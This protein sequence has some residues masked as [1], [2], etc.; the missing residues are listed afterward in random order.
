MDYDALVAT[1]SFAA[2]EDRKCVNVTVI[3]DSIPEVL[4]SFNVTLEETPGLDGR[5]DLDPVVAI[6]EIIDS[7]SMLYTSHHYFSLHVIG[8]T[9]SGCCWS[10]GDF[11]SS[12]RKCWCD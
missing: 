11:F 4:E 9:Y 12:F 1:I 2:C 6:I 3:D 8:A 5:I 10:G 7:N